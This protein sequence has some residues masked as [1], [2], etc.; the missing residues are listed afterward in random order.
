[1]DCCRQSLYFTDL[2]H[3]IAG[4]RAIAADPEAELV[5]VKNRLSPAVDSRH[6][7]GYR[8]VLVNLRLR[9]EEAR[10]LN[11]DL[12][13]WELQLILISFAR[14][15]VPRARL[16]FRGLEH[17]LFAGNLAKKVYGAESCNFSLD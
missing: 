12:H 8:D 13:V 16:G 15:K 9:T 7:A 6:T 11:L 5:H 1:M 4:L 14:I 2:A 10:R 3:L 17:R